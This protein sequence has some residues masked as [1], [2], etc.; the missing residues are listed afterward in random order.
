MLCGRGGDTPRNRHT[1]QSPLKL[2]IAIFILLALGAAIGWVA[3][4]RMPFPSSPARSA[5]GVLQLSDGVTYYKNGDGVPVLLLAS[6]GREASDFNELVLALNKNGYCTFAIESA[7][8][9]GTSALPEGATLHE[10]AAQALQVADVEGLEQFALIGHAYGNRVVRTI[11]EDNP[12]RVTAVILLAAG[13]QKPIAPKADLALRDIFDPR[14]STKKRL[15][16]IRYAFFAGDNEIPEYWRKGWHTKAAIA[17]G[18]A[19]A[20]TADT[21]WQSGGTAPMLVVQPEKDRIAPKA[22][23]AD[24]LQAR[25]PDRVSLVII[26]NAGHAL[27][28]EQ[29]AAV[30]DAVLTFLDETLP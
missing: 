5:V 20:A 15:A 27:L 26:P 16:D 23:T 18:K 13:G 1:A 7:G 2:R 19:V 3:Q 12:E 8:I 6:A 17:Q 29:P 11:S 30:R 4:T 21:A 25:F 24:I 22:D 28:P 9:G 10:Y 14:H